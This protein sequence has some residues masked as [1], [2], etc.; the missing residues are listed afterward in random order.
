[1]RPPY[2][3]T[4]VRLSHNAVNHVAEE[5][6]A[7]GDVPL[8]S[9]LR[10]ARKKSGL[11]LIDVAKHL[12]VT[13]ATVSRWEGGLDLARLRAELAADAPPAGMLPPAPEPSFHTPAQRSLDDDD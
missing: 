11:R 7:G 6:E 9:D 4:D 8:A 1:M 10:E 3:A 2:T 13:H 5:V 12:G